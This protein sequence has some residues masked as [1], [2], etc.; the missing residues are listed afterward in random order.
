MLLWQR[1]KAAG[2]PKKNI[3]TG[4][5]PSGAGGPGQKKGGRIQRQQ[6]RHDDGGSVADASSARPAALAY[7]N[8]PPAPPQIT[9]DGTPISASAPRTN[10]PTFL[11]RQAAAQKAAQMKQ[12][13][14]QL[15]GKGR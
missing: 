3:F 9:N 5:Q 11:I 8:G 14:K 6:R 10:D 1:A 13:V 12:R 15:E 4:L 7:G 2:Q